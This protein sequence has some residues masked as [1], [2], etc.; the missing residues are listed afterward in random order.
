MKKEKIIIYKEKQTM[1]GANNNPYIIVSMYLFDKMKD[2]LQL[3][4][5]MALASYPHLADEFD[6][7][8]KRIEDEAEY[9][10]GNQN[11]PRTIKAYKKH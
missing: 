6:W 8:L 2:R 10:A 1:E 3:A 9:F 4:K 7:L 5:E 11:K